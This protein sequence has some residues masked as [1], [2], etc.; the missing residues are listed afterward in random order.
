MTTSAQARARLHELDAL[1][2][3]SLGGILLVNVFVFHA[4]YAYYSDFYGAFDGQQALI[5]D[6]IAALAAGKFLLV[7]AF[8]FG[9]GIALQHRSRG[10]D[11][12]P[13]FVRRMLALALIGTLH[14][15][16][17]WFGDILLSYALLGLLFL[18]LRGRS[19]RELLVLAGGAIFFRPLYYVGCALFGWPEVGAKL[20]LPLEDFIDALQSSSYAE[21]FWLRMEEFF[22]FT[23][24]NLV[25]FIPKT[26]GAM[27]LGFVACRM[28]LVQQLRARRRR[29]FAL[30]LILVSSA[31]AWAV[32]KMDFFALFDLERHP[33]VRPMLIALNVLFETAMG[34]GYIL[35]LLL[36]FRRSGR[37][38]RLLAGAGRMSLSN[39]ILQSILC[40]TLFNAYGIGWYGTLKPS[41][42][43]L[44]GVA[45]FGVNLG[46]SWLVLRSFERG[47]LEA[48]S[49]RLSS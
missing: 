21:I 33:I 41:E 10:E 24:E 49:R 28:E 34:L 40:V 17:L 7:F 9:Y 39:Y 6:V 45:V 12:L 25:W 22:V 37:V 38:T 11:F 48:I 18:P 15:L 23:P 19:D 32:F 44:V 13:Y 4:P 16:L 27:T 43:L 29:F 42:L 8:L 46:V 14:V 20:S 31:L 1:R 3:V 5:V 47:P 26:L 2:G 30:G 36:M 35:L